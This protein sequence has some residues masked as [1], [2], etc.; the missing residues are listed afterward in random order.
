[1]KK[2]EIGVST[3]PQWDKKWEDIFD[4]YQQDLRHAYYINAFLNNDDK[5]LEIA[6][7]SFRDTAKLNNLDIDC[8][9]TDFSFK[10]IELAQN[11]FPELKK[12]IF[13][14]DAFHM[15]NIDDNQFD[16]TYHNGFWVLFNDDKDIINLAKEQARITKSKMIVTVHNGHNQQFIDYFEKLSKDDELYKIR[17]FKKEE[18]TNLMLNVCK[19]V[20]IIPVGK[21]KKY[22]EDELINKGLWQKEILN[23]FFEV[24][25][26]ANLSNSERL[27]CIGNLE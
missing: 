21:G 1:M 20:K 6:A 25:K 26:E 27:M 9:G 23:P 15:G 12:K 8:Y 16:I 18:I 3:L 2:T 14:S 22:F 10:A 4:H 17:F 24:T 13:Q 5:V 7:G 19:S 11:K